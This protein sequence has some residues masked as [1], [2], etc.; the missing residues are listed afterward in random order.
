[1][2]ALRHSARQVLSSA[3]STS[4][5]STSITPPLRSQRIP[6]PL[7]PISSISAFSTSRLIRAAKDDASGATPAEESAETKEAAFGKGLGLKE[8][9]EAQ[10]TGKGSAAGKSE[11]ETKLA[12]REAKIKELT[13]QLLYGK[14]DMQNLQRRSAE[15]KAQA[16]DFAI[17]KFA[18][19]LTASLDVL[20]LALRSV[21][22]ALRQAPS[23][24]KDAQDPRK[25]LAELYSGVELTSKSITD[26][27]GR[28][29]VTVFDPT[30]EKFDPALHE[31]MYQAPV[32][33]KTPGT[34]LEC[35]KVGFKI[36]G[37]VLRPAQVGVVQET[38]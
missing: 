38:S 3:A 17:T 5:L 1:M 7:A 13:D 14:A 35:S 6:S 21:P 15:E 20:A 30:G 9:G 25:A 29:G 34:V 24:V 32:P 27:L 37:R 11:A 28:H 33:G 18:R 19:D 4:R 10:S 12:E 36:K 16:S 26:M 8:T 2:S 31:A 22:E 23:E